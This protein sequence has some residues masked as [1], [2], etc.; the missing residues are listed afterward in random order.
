MTRLEFRKH[1]GNLTGAG[2]RMFLYHSER[3]ERMVRMM[4]LREREAF[5]TDAFRSASIGDTRMAGV[6]AWHAGI[7]AT[8]PT[9]TE[10]TFDFR[11]VRCSGR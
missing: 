2:R 9:K 8:L 5:I 3:S 11:G 4:Y 10:R 1:L 7:R 6:E